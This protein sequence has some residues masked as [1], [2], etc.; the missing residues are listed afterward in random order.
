MNVEELI[1]ALSRFPKDLPVEI[2]TVEAFTDGTVRVR[3]EDVRYNG[4]KN[5][6]VL[7]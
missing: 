6:V 7:S 3:V 2:D 5:A 4:S 1:D